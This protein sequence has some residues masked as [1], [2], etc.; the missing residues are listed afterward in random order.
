MSGYSPCG[1]TSSEALT[2]HCRDSGYSPRA[3]GQCRPKGDD[4]SKQHPG[5]QKKLLG[6]DPNTGEGRKAV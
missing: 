5:I 2:H 4:A 3:D 1:D 6:R